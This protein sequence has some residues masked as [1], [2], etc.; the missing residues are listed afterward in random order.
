MSSSCI[1]RPNWVSPLVRAQGAGLVDPED[2]VLVAVE[3]HRLAV[4]LEVVP[5]GFAV[6]EEGLVRHKP[7]LQQLTGGIIDIDQQGAARPAVFEPVV[8]RAIDLHQLAQTRPPLAQLMRG[9][10][11]G[12]LRF[13]DPFSDHDLAHAFRERRELCTSVSFSWARVGPKSAYFLQFSI[14]LQFHR[15]SG[16]LGTSARNF[17]LR[18]FQFS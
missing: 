5:G 8:I 17:S 7:Q 14:R 1:A 13:P 15:I 11:L 2:A 10:L 16:K 4:A 18:R 3:G 12:A 6:G 9:G